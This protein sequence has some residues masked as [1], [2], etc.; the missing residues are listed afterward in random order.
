MMQH[1][2]GTFAQTCAIFDRADVAFDE[3]ETRPLD[4]F[5]ESLHLVEI[6]LVAGREIVEA[7]YPLIKLQQRFQQ[8]RTNE[9]G[10]PGDRPFPRRAL[11]LTLCVLVS[12][13]AEMSPNGHIVQ[14]V[15]IRL[16]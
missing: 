9:S 12:V 15:G 2:V 1:G 5:N 13:I 3:I 8:I 10:R 11:E 14:V 16:A 6:A 7:G 4:R